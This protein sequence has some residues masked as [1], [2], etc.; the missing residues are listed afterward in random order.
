MPLTDN[1]QK[2]ADQKAADAARKE[3]ENDPNRKDPEGQQ[4]RMDA[5]VKKLGLNK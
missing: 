3:W 2:A 1:E 5:A 4:D